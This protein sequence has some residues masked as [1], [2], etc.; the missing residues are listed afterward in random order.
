[1]QQIHVSSHIFADSFRHFSKDSFDVSKMLKVVFVGESA[2]DDGGP[3]CEI[4]QLLLHDIACQS[5]LFGG[6]PDHVDALSRK[7]KLLSE[8]CSQQL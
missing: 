7:K 6:W 1:M 4:F 3:R 2:I 5:G 8:R